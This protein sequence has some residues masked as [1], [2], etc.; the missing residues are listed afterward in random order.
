VL[1]RPVLDPA[2]VGEREHEG[3]HAELLEQALAQ[4]PRAVRALLAYLLPV[5]RSRALLACR[6]RSSAPGSGDLSHEV[7]D[8]TQEALA[9]L[10]ADDANVLR[11]WDPT[12]GL[13]LRN[14]VGLVCARRIHA[15]LRARQRRA[16]PEELTLDGELTASDEGTDPVEGVIASR[17]MFSRI[18]EQ[19]RDEVSARGMELF[20][21]LIVEERPVDLVCAE[22]G[23]SADAVY[24]WRSRLLR[25]ARILAKELDSSDE[26]SDLPAPAPI[27][28]R[29]GVP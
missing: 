20:H 2:G 26:R 10:F 11:S 17:Q 23:M 15:L 1:V 16:W 6:R 5:V 28:L 19:L 14:F 25:R 22:L 12:R 9:T 8:L 13:S 18:L 4:D 24:A 3:T 27:R 29:A 7:D 21:A